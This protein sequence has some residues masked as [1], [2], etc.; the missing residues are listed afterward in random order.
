MQISKA[1]IGQTTPVTLDLKSLPRPQERIVAAV[2][3]FRDQTGQYKPSETAA[4][5]STAVTQGGTNILIKAMEESGWFIPIERENVSNL[6]NERKIIRSSR[7]QYQSGSTPNAQVLPPL[8]YAG[9]ILEGGI[10][11]YDANVV[12]GGAG[13]RYFGAGGSGQYRQDRVTIYLRA[14]STSS[15]KILKTVYTTKTILSQAFDGGLFRFVRFGRLLEAET[16]FTYNE[17]S[18]MAVI[19]AVEKAVHSLI[20]EGIMDGL[21]NVDE[22]EKVLSEQVKAYQEE[23]AN[24]IKTDIFGRDLN[25]RRSVVGLTINSTALRY[26]GD[27]PDPASRAGIELAAN[28]SITNNF[29]VGMGY[30]T[31]SVATKN[32][33]STNVSYLEGNG[34]FRIL[35]YDRISPFVT[36][37]GGV[38]SENPDN[39]FDFTTGFLPKVQIGGGLEYLLS[40][41]FGVSLALDHNFV[42]SDRLDRV[43]QGLYNDSYWRLSLGVN[44]YFGKPLEGNR[45]FKLPN[46]RLNEF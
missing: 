16:G 38:I 25:Q 43:T 23:K 36:F 12:T 14:V 5:W 44:F 10:V 37:G 3:K 45:Q 33:F 8:L 41:N 46:K 1:R 35:P 11:S 42:M 31:S 21:W 40:N 18:E 4:N 17:P 27:Y 24:L 28:F 19:E 9:V 29:A 20:I 32:S 30:G 26:N 34:I 2:Y 22:N 39:R 6:L 7:S 15:G 13:L